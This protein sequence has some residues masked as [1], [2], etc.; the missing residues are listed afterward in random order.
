MKSHQQ[1]EAGTGQSEKAES[2]GGLF[3]QV[4]CGI[5]GKGPWTF[6]KGVGPVQQLVCVITNEDQDMTVLMLGSAAPF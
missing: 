5:Q 6:I 2:L 4:N 3:P 1:K